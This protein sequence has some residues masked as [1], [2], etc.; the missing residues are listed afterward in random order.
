[1]RGREAEGE[2]T[3][4]RGSEDRRRV[5][6]FG[7]GAVVVGFLAVF[8]GMDV[9]LGILQIPWE[10]ADLEEPFFRGPRDSLL[11]PLVE[12]F[13]ALHHD[14]PRGLLRGR[15]FALCGFFRLLCFVG[16]FFW[17]LT[18]IFIAIVDHDV[19]EGDFVCG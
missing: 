12:R 14:R 18:L 8:G 9:A 5:R 3:R 15:L 2:R 1:M 11:G 4:P 10:L 16:L 7:L 6:G 13:L 17:V 19:D